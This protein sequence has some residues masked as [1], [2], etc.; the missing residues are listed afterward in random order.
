MLNRI[1]I[2]GRLTADP[3]LRQ[4]ESGISVISFGIACERSYVTKGKERETDFFNVSAW[5]STADFISQY[6]QKGDAIIIDGA[7]QSRKYT[8]KEGN[9]RTA[10]DIVANQVHF[11]GSKRD[12]STEAPDEKGHNSFPSPDDFGGFDISEIDDF[13][14]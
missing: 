5:R 6:F 14:L 2:M 10:I 1:T 7:L 13:S 4:T 3:E 11:A 8:D 12:K 9:K